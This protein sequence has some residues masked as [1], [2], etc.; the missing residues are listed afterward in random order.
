MANS[1]KFCLYFIAGNYV[2]TLVWERSKGQEQ[3]ID[4]EIVIVKKL[5]TVLMKNNTL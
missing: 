2:T 3:K 5:I 4:I 1:L